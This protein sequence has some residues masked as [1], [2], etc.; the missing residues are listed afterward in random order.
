MELEFDKEIDAILR[1]ARGPAGAAVSTAAGAHID[2]DAVA[3]F[4][5]NAL[6]QHTRRMYVEHFADCHDCRKLLS[7][8]IL[9]NA[10]AVETA[11]SAVAAPA[12]EAAV[13]WYL[14]IFK[15][16]TLA[17]T[18]GALVL[19]FAGIIGLQM[20]QQRNAET[21]VASVTDQEQSLA[22][23]YMLCCQ[24]RK[25]ANASRIALE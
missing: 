1:R 12:V 21:S 19:G 15:T 22:N 18:M 5:E 4:S 20:M 23:R 14:N 16:P 10:E 25:L 2:A 13:P 11:A 7:H 3:A 6:P 17:L 8:T 24:R 9:M